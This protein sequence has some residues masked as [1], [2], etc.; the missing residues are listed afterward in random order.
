MSRSL[1]DRR[2][3]MKTWLH[4][5]AAT[6]M[7]TDDPE[8]K[9]VFEFFRSSAILAQ[10][11]PHGIATD[12]VEVT[13]HSIFLVPLMPSDATFDPHYQAYLSSEMFA[14][15]FSP[16]TRLLYIVDQPP[17]TPEWQGLV[18]LHEAFHSYAAAHA[19]YDWHDLTS[20]A[21]QE[22]AAFN[23]SHRLTLQLGGLI[24]ERALEQEIRRLT[25][26]HVETADALAVAPRGPYVGTLDQAFEPALS[27]RE[28][29]I[30]QTTL[31]IHAMFEFLGN[32]TSS[33]NRR[34]VSPVRFLE[35][36][37]ATNSLVRR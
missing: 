5:A 1:E 28:R 11:I 35:A 21:E 14:A 12:H 29:N 2:N 15:G 24:Y 7:H 13:P 19:P 16:D 27:E 32:N 37:Y 34:S 20:Y 9:N 3:V 30:R 33:D 25:R 26:V 18:L 31:W 22:F 6:V 8:A 10:P 4:S 23:F 17:L 36:L